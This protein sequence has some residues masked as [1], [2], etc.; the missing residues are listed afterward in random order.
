MSA[1]RVTRFALP[2]L[3]LAAGT[4]LADEV[5]PLFR[6]D[7]VIKAVLTAPIA[8]VYGQSG[9]SVRLYHPGY[10]SYVAEDGSTQ[11]LDVSIRTRGHFRREF[12]DLPPLQLNFRK[13]QVRDSLFDGQDKLKLVAPC[14]N[15]E[16]YQQYVILEYLA[17]RTFEL[18]TDY[19]FATRLMRLSYIDSDE[20]LPPRTHLVFVIE[21]ENDMAR[22][23]GLKTLRLDQVEF[24]ELD[25]PRTA[26]VQLFQFL[27]GNN[28][29]S[30]IAGGEGQCCHNT[31][32]LG[33]PDMTGGRIPVPFD[34]DM[35]GLVNAGY[36]NPPDQVPI[37]DVR[38]RYF[39]GICQADDVLDAAIAHM[40]S[41]RGAIEDLFRNSEQLDSRNKSKSLDYIDSFYD[42]LESRRRVRIEIVNRCRGRSYLE[43]MLEAQRASTGP[44]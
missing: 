29:Y 35:S 25:H 33:R 41:K 32:I 26:L 31:Q 22:R 19:S 42:I 44:T 15:D 3:L 30:V 17:Y 10:W 7:T 38:Q 28:D 20:K 13:S 1:R 18:V 4:V 2:C 6:D 24:D 9:Q 12:C 16:R 11:R 34:F 40:Q 5:L 23:L 8:Q 14:V 43:R 27:I 36:A 21:D 39:Y 37:V